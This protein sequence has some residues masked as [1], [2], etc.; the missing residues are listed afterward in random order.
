MNTLGEFFAS[1]LSL[2]DDFDAELPTLPCEFHDIKLKNSWRIQLS[3]VRN[4]LK[5]L[6]VNEAVGPDCITPWILRNCYMELSQPLTM[7][8]RHICRSGGVDHFI[9]Y[10]LLV[11]VE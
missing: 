2:S 9:I 10:R 8:F 1:K 4:I 5:N 11:F 6:D 3:K 7:L